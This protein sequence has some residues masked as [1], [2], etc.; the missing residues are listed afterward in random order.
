MYVSYTPAYVR[1]FI[2][3]TYYI[4]STMCGRIKGTDS[5]INSI[6]R[7]VGIYRTGGEFIEPEAVRK[8]IHMPSLAFYDGF[9]YKSVK[10][11]SRVQYRNCHTTYTCWIVCIFPD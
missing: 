9:S 8:R 7:T 11:P 2:C 4:R 6:L 3:D 1:K 10:A 5:S